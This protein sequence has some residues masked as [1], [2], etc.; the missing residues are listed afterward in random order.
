M[1]ERNETKR[2]EARENNLPTGFSTL[3]A[4]RTGDR[5]RGRLIVS[6]KG[7][8]KNVS[9]REREAAGEQRTRQTTGQALRRDDK[10]TALTLGDRSGKPGSERSPPAQ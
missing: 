1:A 3:G 4:F 10:E 5:K 8:V 9:P 2:G 7:T 6:A